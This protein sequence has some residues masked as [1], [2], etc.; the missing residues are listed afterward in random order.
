MSD[1]RDFYDSRHQ[2][3]VI[4]QP[5]QAPHLSIMDPVL[6]THLHEYNS[7]LYMSDACD[8]YD[9]RDQLGVIGHGCPMVSSGSHARLLTCPLCSRDTSMS[10][11]QLYMTYACEFYDSHARLLTFPLCPLCSRHFEFSA[12]QLF[13]SNARNLC[14]C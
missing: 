7:A 6:K 1:A 11:N 4:G 3:G 13:M 14:D 2:L 10:T 9:S 5:R 8:F 12:S